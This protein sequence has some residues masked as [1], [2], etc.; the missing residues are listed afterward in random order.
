MQSNQGEKYVLERLHKLS[1]CFVSLLLAWFYLDFN[2]F[3]FFK[4]LTN[5]NILHYDLPKTFL[6]LS[7]TLT[8]I[9]G[10][11]TS[12]MNIYLFDLNGQL[13]LIF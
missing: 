4:I 1:W 10:L 3:L 6:G 8:K 7:E 13:Y 11:I 12:F 5:L 9:L 2:P